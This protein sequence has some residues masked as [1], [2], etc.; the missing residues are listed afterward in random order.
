[1]TLMRSIAWTWTLISET[2][3]DSA[4]EPGAL[5]YGGAPVGRATLAAEGRVVA[6]LANARMNGVSEPRP[7]M[8]FC[9]RYTFDG[10]RIVMHLDGA[11]RPP[12]MAEPQVRMARFKGDAMI[13]TATASDGSTRSF[14]WHQLS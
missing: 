2:A 3:A 8:A 9:G 13:L 4:S 11:T 12:M 7:L 1:M 10:T 14:I 5:L 6:V